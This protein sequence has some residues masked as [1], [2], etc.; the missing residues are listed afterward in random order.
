MPP[1]STIRSAPG[2]KTAVGKT[3]AAGAVPEGVTCVHAG[4]PPRPLALDKAHPSFSC[5]LPLPAPPRTVIALAAASYTAA[6]EF[7]GVGAAPATA[8]G[9]QVGV[10]PRPFALPRTQTVLSA[11][12]KT[13][14]RFEP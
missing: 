10:P 2:S 4:V 12:P 11:S 9:I 3:L 6:W 1:N 5:G 7:R 13:I 14:I 8:S